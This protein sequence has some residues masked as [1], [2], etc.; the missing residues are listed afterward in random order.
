M[1]KYHKFYFIVFIVFIITGYF[2]SDFSKAYNDTTTHPALTDEIMDFYN[3]FFDPKI[4]DEE[5]EWIIQGS[6][7]E[8]TI[9]RWIN[10]FY[11]PIY[12]QGWTGEKTG[13]MPNWLVQS[14]S[15][16]LIA[17]KS[18]VSSLEW[19]HNQNLQ[20]SYH[21]FLGNHTW[22]KAIYELA[23]N[24]NKKE[25]YYTL[26]FI[27]HLI[28]DATVPEHTRNDTHAEPVQNITGDLGSPYE[29]YTAKFDRQNF[30][31]SEELKDKD[32]KPNIKNTINE[33]LIDLAKYSNN[34]FFNKDTIDNSKYKLPD[35]NIVKQNCDNE[36]CYGIDE[37][38][39]KFKLVMKDIKKDGYKIIETYTIKSSDDYYPILSDYFALLSRQAI[40]NGAGIINLFHQE[41]EKAKQNPEKL[42]SPPKPNTSDQTISFLNEQTKSGIAQAIIKTTA[43]KFYRDVILKPADILKNIFSQQEPQTSSVISLG[44]ETQASS[45]QSA[46]TQS[47]G[48]QSDQLE[49]ASPTV[50]N[51]N[52]ETLFPN[53]KTIENPTSNIPTYVYAIPPAKK[54]ASSIIDRYGLIA[55]PSAPGAGGG[56]NQSPT[57]NMVS[58]N[59]I[60][61]DT[62]PSDTTPPSISFFSVLECQNSLSSQ[63]CLIATTT[64]NLLWNSNDSDLNYYELSYGANI[65]TTTATSTSLTLQNNTAYSF[66]L[67]AVDKSN[68]WSATSTVSIEIN[69]QPVIINEIAWM[70]TAT[71]SSD[72]WIELYNPTNRTIKME[73]FVLYS[74]T[75]LAP[76]IKLTSLISPFGY[77]LL[78][79]TDDNAVPDIAAD[80]IYT[81]ALNNSGEILVLSYVANN[82][83]TTID[84]TVLNSSASWPAGDNSTKETMQKND[85][86]WCTAIA[87]PKTENNCQN[88]A[89]QTPPT[90]TTPPNAPTI[91][92]PSSFNQTFTSSQITF[93]GTAEA[94]SVVTASSATTTVSNLGEWSLA[95]NLNQGTTTINF[96]AEDLA[97][98]QSQTISVQLFIDSIGP[99]IDTF[100]I[101]ECSS[102][103]NCQVATTTL[104]LL[105]NSSAIDLDYYELSY[106]GNISTTIATSTTL[107]LSD[108]TSYV[109]SLRA[110]DKTDNWSATSTKAV[111]INAPTDTTPPNPPTI[112]S[113]SNFNQ[114][115]ATTSIDFQGTAEAI[116]TIKVIYQ[117]NSSTT[118]ATTTAGG[119]GNWSL[120]L[121]FNQ[122]TT[123][124]DFY[125]VD[126]SN[127]I[128]SSTAATLFIDSVG[129]E[130]SS[131][132]ISQCSNSL[133]PE[134]EGCLTAT[135]TL[136]LAWSSS[137]QD[138]DYYELSYGSNTATTTATSTALTL[139]DNSNYDFS[140]RA[141]DQSGNWSSAATT[142]AE[143]NTLPVVINEI[144]WMGTGANYPSDEFIE[145]YNRTSKTISLT[146]W[147][148]YSKTD[149]SPYI[150][151]SGAIPAKNYYLIERKNT[152]DTDESTQSPIKDITAD[153][154]T[155]FSYGLNNSGE[156]LELAMVSNNATT[157][158]D[159]TP[160]GS[161]PA[162]GISAYVS[163]ERFDSL[164]SG[165]IASNWQSNNTLIKNGRDVNNNQ[166][167]ATP[168]ARNSASYLISTNPIINQDITLTKTKSP[169]LV[170]SALT[171]SQD[172][173]LTINSGVVIKFKTG[174]GISLN[175]NGNLL[176]QGASSSPVVFTSFLDDEYGGDL[177]GDTTSTSPAS[178][179][180][181]EVYL[182]S[183][184]SSTVNH[185]IFRYGGMYY[186]GQSSGRALLRIDQA[187]S[188]VQNSIFEYS[189]VSGLKLI[190]S[191]SLISNNTFRNNNNIS[192][193][194]SSGI[195]LE[196]GNPTIINNT[197]QNNKR[198]LYL[199]NDFG[200]VENNVFNNNSQEPILATGV[201]SNFSQNSGS[202]NGVNGIVLNSVQ[203]QTNSA[204]VLSANSLP[205]VLDGFSQINASS[206]L[207][208]KPNTVIKGKNGSGINVFGN[209]IADGINPNDIIFTSSYEPSN[210]GDWYGIRGKPGSFIKIKGTTVKSAGQFVFGG[211]SA[212][213]YLEQSRL[214][215]DN[216][217]FENNQYYGLASISSTSTIKNSTFAKHRT[218]NPGQKSALYLT[219]SNM[220]LENVIFED[221][222]L[223]INAPD[224]PANSAVIFSNLTFINNTSISSP[225]GI[226]GP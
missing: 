76:Y 45:F 55:I 143:I 114:T 16:A 101:A 44:T 134:P 185:A 133:S 83:T 108:N 80:K 35:L 130:I 8:D 176:V 54:P 225:A 56:G 207:T 92:S 159:S 220:T 118:T 19:L 36:F 1:I 51:T 157:T 189:Y 168:K 90:D 72:E 104:H 73:N 115:F 127:N 182:S 12:N 208:I 40:I 58:Q 148:L 121:S 34:N 117:L 184:S 74:S 173:T 70:G 96:Y 177:N 37:N 105:W 85:A 190:N 98:N 218:P 166:I 41:T 226:F 203:T 122:G 170:E 132:S 47:L 153:L 191:P 52:L 39:K 131:F 201:V 7:D 129:P 17:D 66:S 174:S 75:N 69:T 161:W 135:T 100:S 125:A 94:N 50:Q 71:S 5:K 88:R 25:A 155:S 137:N 99:T 15:Y 33:Y 10:H 142:S 210:A 81:G 209:L 38:N 186:S 193:G 149:L 65:S 13:I 82:A 87:T 4:T 144:G 187:I 192:E 147:V 165:N 6:H 112:N 163:M 188:T 32:F 206:T 63:N 97:G 119:S 179:N 224:W 109:F 78:E 124:I 48:I 20:T 145:L 77:Y 141:I 162:G 49:M 68:N 178:G 150:Q 106:A 167:N 110:K 18:P 29:I 212:A 113:P 62:T 139:A 2:L 138:I 196:G 120:N 21:Q 57:P 216:A 107:I 160:S 31:I 116:S 211:T 197:F 152:G 217:I 223:A 219:G 9:P 11:D 30:N 61:L 195:Q 169:Y 140:L 86:S 93:Q 221:N 205:Y 136:N 23:V 171:L 53:T 194:Y 199:I 204:V 164:N 180:W 42:A 111:S 28:E 151:L 3:L 67:R 103:Q 154:W 200:N 183:T 126:L 172:K 198:G 214:E 102:G 84:Q 26:G 27:L 202:G 158:I 89:S 59:T 146:N 95:L 79:R 175:I 60:L 181:K 22:E 43:R 64:I 128:S 215:I 222:T 46:T 156:I 24:N 14:V 213:L 123:T 91:T